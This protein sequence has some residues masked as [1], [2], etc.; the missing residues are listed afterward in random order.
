MHLRAAPLFR[1]LLPFLIVALALG[2]TVPSHAI[3]VSS[4]YKF[5]EFEPF[6]E[7]GVVQAP[8]GSLYTLITNPV[9]TLLR[10]APDGTLTKL[11][12]VGYTDGAMSG[13]LLLASD[14]NFYGIIPGD[15]PSLLQGSIYRLTPDGVVTQLHV[16]TGTG[17]GGFPQ[18][19]LV[20]GPDG[21]LYG[22]TGSAPTLSGI[23]SGDAG[24]IF[25]CALDGTLTTLH[26]FPGGVNLSAP[27]APLTVARDGNFYGATTQ[28]LFR[29]SPAGDY[30]SLH[31]FVTNG[32]SDGLNPGFVQD[33]AGN[34]YGT[35][36]TGGSLDPAYPFA[37]GTVFRCTPDGVVSTLYRFDGG[38]GAL[39]AGPLAVGP[40]GNFYGVL[41]QGG[42]GIGVNFEE[43][44]ALFRVTPAGEVTVV[45]HDHSDT[46][47]RYAPVG[48]TTAADGNLYVFTPDGLLRVQLTGPGSLGLT[49]YTYQVDATDGVAYVG[50]YRTDD[51][52]GAVS[53]DYT[54]ADDTAHSGVDYTASRGTVRWADGDAAI[55]TVQIPLGV[56]PPSVGYVTKQFNVHLSQP[57]G[58]ATLL[59]DQATVA[60]GHSTFEPPGVGVSSL[61]AFSGGV[62]GATI[63][64][65]YPQADGSLVGATVGSGYNGDQGT[66][67]RRDADGSLHLLAAT[68]FLEQSALTPGRDGNFYGTRFLPNH[69]NPE[70]CRLTPDGTLTALIDLGPSESEE[71]DFPYRAL[72]PVRDGSFYGAVETGTYDTPHHIRVFRVTTDGT[73][74]TLRTLDGNDPVYLL[75]GVDGQLYG[76]RYTDPKYPGGFVFS[77]SPDRGGY[78]VVYDFSQGGATGPGSPITPLFQASNGRFYGLAKAPGG[79]DQTVFYQLKSN[80][81]AKILHPFT[82]REG[83]PNSEFV[84]G[85]DGNFYGTVSSEAEPAGTVLY[86]LT[87]Q[88][89]FTQLYYTGL[90]SRIMQLLAHRSDGTTFFTDDINDGRDLYGLDPAGST[91]P[92]LE[93]HLYN[94]SDFVVNG[95]VGHAIITRTGNLEAPL[96][97]TYTIGGTARPGVDYQARSGT[98]TI[99]AGRVDGR[100][101]VRTVP[102]PFGAATSTY[103]VDLQLNDSTDGSYQLSPG[104]AAV[105]FKISGAAN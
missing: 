3:G 14:G 31:D 83:D 72:V 52:Q 1:A 8:D 67:F 23:P 99:P 45:Y 86:R 12:V 87:R 16:F 28:S 64:G 36:R 24:A 63:H 29:L 93:M 102:V 77:V 13:P 27:Q 17:D 57:G 42:D 94:G 96:T 79:S 89:D 39:P 73:Q 51:T 84:A 26:R 48:P 98:L 97:V 68:T 15:S 71:G 32:F 69:P 9:N 4:F 55:K 43:G 50:F 41:S 2:S 21:A 6:Y 90:T 18:P 65:L 33:A 76:L 92:T 88:G 22:V 11:P 74:T 37:D 19:G 44:G 34:L 62:D 80:G 101:A 105:E 53:V 75:E 100:I 61:F 47:L 5:D 82:R 95:S 20:Q 103:T 54:T 30:V 56:V 59:S 35:T 78:K 66:I 91:K 46:G 49:N 81:K 7:G 25:R 10:F 38:E 40:D 85:G 70:I 58:G 104:S 60:V